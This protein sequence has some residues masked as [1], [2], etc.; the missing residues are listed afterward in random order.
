[1]KKFSI[2]GF[3]FTT[4][5]VAA[6][7]LMILLPET[8]HARPS[9]HTRQ[10]RVSDQRLAELE[11]L[12]SLSRMRGKLVTVPIGFGRV[13]P[14]RL[15]RRRRSNMESGLQKLQRILQAAAQESNS[16]SEESVELPSSFLEDF[17][18]QHEGETEDQ[19][20]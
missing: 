6:V 12:L 13:D 2:V 16:I 11:T 8:V 17:G 4:V 9:G 15:G 10:K 1:M 5:V 18:H 7:L 20:I 19:F 14:D 3:E